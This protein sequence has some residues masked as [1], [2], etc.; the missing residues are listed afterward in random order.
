MAEV[1][2]LGKQHRN[3]TLMVGTNKKYNVLF[4]FTEKLY[5]TSDI[6]ELWKYFLLEKTDNVHIR[7]IVRNLDW[8]VNWS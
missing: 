1:F 3:I 7:H 2:R 4:G 5:H 6:F 8:W